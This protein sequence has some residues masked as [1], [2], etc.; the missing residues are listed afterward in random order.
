MKLFR[1]SPSAD[2]IAE[3]AAGLLLVMALLYG[4][5]SRG[6]GD[7]VVHLA[8]LPAL[9]IGVMR[10]R[11][12]DATRLQRLFL[13]WLLAAFALVA[14]QL[15]PL[16]ASVFAALPQRAAVLAD[17]KSADLQP[18]WLPMTLDI[19]G[20]VRALLALATFAAAW[21]LA[22]TLAHDARIRLIKL[23]VG[24]AL[25]MALLGFAQAAA[26]S[27]S[28]LRFHDYHHPVGAIGL[29]ANRNHFADL[30]GM[31]VPL[32]LGLAAWA[33]ARHRAAHAAVW[34]AAA[35]VLFLASAL[36]YSRAGIALTFVAAAA[37]AIVLARRGASSAHPRR[38]VLPVMG[39]AIVGLAV[40][41]YAW[42]G[43]ANR[44]TQDPLEDLRWQYV[45]YGLDAAKAYLPWG[46]GLGSFR[47]VYAPFEPLAAMQQVHALHA[48]NDLL[49]IAV[50]AGLPGLINLFIFVVL[51]AIAA[52]T[53]KRGGE[54]LSGPQSTIIPAVAFAAF[55]PLTHSFV[56]YPLRTLSVATVF[57]ILVAVLTAR[58][59][60][61]SMT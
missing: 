2:S 24:V 40:A 61:R 46:S 49:E 7:L 6:V 16:P 60:S 35:S 55:V 53:R 23:V 26:G 36:S 54:P 10:W 41:V 42:D 37:T 9:A 47:D 18:A 51:L 32:A 1:S 15:L 39:I 58:T 38:Y 57:A 59:A 34:Y 4:G 21:L 3:L 44:L 17:L 20:T 27:H 25:A 33:Q 22:S 29:F 31:V 56:D 30:M 11:H 14:L 43:I 5:G 13:Y 8:A 48:H 50:E 28:S 45:R 19:W 52:V 12:A